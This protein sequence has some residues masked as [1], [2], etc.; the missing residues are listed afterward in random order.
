MKVNKLIFKQKNM[1]DSLSFEVE[2]EIETDEFE[3]LIKGH[4]IS[5]ININTKTGFIEIKTYSDNFLWYSL[6]DIEFLSFKMSPDK[7]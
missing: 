1:E 4:K 7:Y 5:Q 6:N 2:Q 3:S